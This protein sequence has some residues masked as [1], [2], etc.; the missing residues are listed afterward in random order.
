LLFFE[1]YDI[2]YRQSAL[3]YQMVGSKSPEGGE[4]NAQQI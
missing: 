3:L 2:M 4:M 1:C